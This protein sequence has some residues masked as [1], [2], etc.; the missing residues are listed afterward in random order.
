MTIPEA[1]QLILQAGVLAR[2]G[3]IFVLD[4]GDPV[5]ILDLA[6][7]LIR[8]SGYRPYSDIDIQIVGMR[9][10]EKLF[11]ELLTA[12]EGVNATT[13]ERIFVAKPT[14]LD[15][16]LLRQILG[17]FSQNPPALAL[18]PQDQAGTVQF[19]RQFLPDFKLVTN[20]Q[21]A[22]LEAAAGADVG[23]R[24]F[25]LQEEIAEDRVK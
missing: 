22:A 10:G 16:P 17:A 3:E 14:A 8:L 4:M 20:A 23:G 7:T 25:G 9:P 18:P 5:R 19:I 12:E 11:E 21:P 15:T 2:G 24:G 13:H 1:V 6:T